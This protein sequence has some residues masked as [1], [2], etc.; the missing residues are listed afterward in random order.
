MQYGW[1]MEFPSLQYDWA[2]EFSDCK[3]FLAN[4]LSIDLLISKSH[5]PSMYTLSMPTTH[6]QILSIDSFDGEAS[7]LKDRISIQYNIYRSQGGK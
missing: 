5:G 6:I 4:N 3:I 1:A 2:R 7:A